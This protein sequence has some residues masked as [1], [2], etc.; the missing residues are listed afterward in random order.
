M[1]ARLHNFDCACLCFGYCSYRGGGC[2]VADFKFKNTQRPHEGLNPAV[3]W[4]QS[5]WR[6]LMCRV[7][8]KLFMPRGDESVTF[9]KFFA[10]IVSPTVKFIFS[11]AS[12]QVFNLSIR[13]VFFSLSLFQIIALQRIKQKGGLDPT[14]LCSCHPLFSHFDWLVH[15]HMITSCWRGQTSLTFSAICAKEDDKS[16]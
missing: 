15:T 16:I 9:Y 6:T 1:C 3:L 12:F 5:L 10:W 4:T 8:C 2:G 11:L 13:E 7:F 14:A